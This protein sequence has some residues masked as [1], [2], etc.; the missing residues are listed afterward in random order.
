MQADYALNLELDSRYIQ[1]R[2][3]SNPN[4]IYFWMYI[5]DYI[6]RYVATPIFKIPNNP[7]LH[8]N[9]VLKLAFFFSPN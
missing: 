4:E 5:W 6:I 9:M 3:T 2:D 7:N 1:K 8:L